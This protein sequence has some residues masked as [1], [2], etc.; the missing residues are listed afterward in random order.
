M[1]NQVLHIDC[2]DEKG[3]VYRITE[4]LYNH[5][6]NIVSNHEFVDSPTRHFVMRTAFEGEDTP[7]GVFKDLEKALPKSANI[8]QSEIGNRSIVI[9]Q[10]TALPGRLA[11]ALQLWR[12][13]CYNRR[14]HQQS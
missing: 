6:L 1:G 13:S 7:D 5:K 4:V 11:V 3:L 2:P 14:C 8:R 12:N 9:M 10:R